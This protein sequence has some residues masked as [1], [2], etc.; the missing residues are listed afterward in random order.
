MNFSIFAETPNPTGAKQFAEDFFKTNAPR[1]AP[2][3]VYQKPVL[4]QCY[5]S[6]SYK[7]TPVFVFQNVE[8]GF[9]VV[10]QN[11]NRF[12]VA[13]Y[14]PEGQ[15]QAD[16]VPPQLSSL[17]QFYEDSLQIKP[18]AIQKTSAG[19][20]VMTPLLDEAGISLNQFS[21]PEVGGCPTGCV[22]TAFVQI[23]AYYKYP[24]KGVGSHCYTHPTYG[25]LCADFGNTTYNWDNPT[26]EDYKKLS[27][28]V[29]IAMD[30]NYCESS[31]GS[32]PSR[33][34]YPQAMSDYFR[35]YLNNGFTDSYFIINEINNRRPAYA[36]LPGDPGHA[37]VLDGYDTDG[38][39]HINFGWGG[40]YN[41]YYVLNNNSTFTVGYKFG[42]NVSFTCFMTPY[43][44]KTDIQDS[45]AL[46]AV[47][48]SLNGSTGWDLKQPV[49]TWKGVLM[50]NGRVISLKLNNG[51]Y[52]T[53][54]G[55][56]PSEIGNL[57]AL[58]MLDLLGQFDGELPA[59]IANLTMLKT[60]SIYAGAGKLKAQLP[61][62]V[63]NLV[64]LEI[65]EIPMHAEG[66]IPSSIGSLTKLQR[67]V[68]NSGN[69]TGN[70]PNEIG[71]LKNLTYLNLK[72]NKLTGSIPTG[73][74]N[75][76]QL[77]EIHLDENQLSGSL[78][79][80]IGNLTE[81]VALTLNDNQLSGNL[82]ESM[83]N[84][85]KLTTLHLYNNQFTGE[86][87][88]SLGNLSLIKNLN[89]S[90]N[91]FISLP[92]EIDNW[93]NIV[94]LN[95]NNNQLSSLPRSINNLTNLKTLYANHNQLAELPENFGAFPSL[96]NIDLSY[97]Q[98][99]VF[100][101]E[102][103]LLTKLEHIS[104][105]KNKIKEFPAGITMLPTTLNYL[106]LDSNE[107][108]DRIPKAL[109]ENENLSS[110]LLSY[111]RFTFE[112]LPVSD[113]LRNG[114]GN[115]KPV[116]L[117]KKIFKTAIGDTLRI[118]IREI[119]PFTLTTNQYN[120]ISAEN[121]KAISDSPNPILTI[122]IND[123]NIKNKYYCKVTNPSSPTYTYV[124][125][126]TPFRLP[127]LNFVTTDTISFQLATE[128]ELIAEKYKNSYVVSS[129]NVP[130]K[131]VEDKIVT[132][133][134]PLKVRGAIKWQ[135]S[136]DGTTWFDLSENMSQNDLKANF[137]SVNQQELV[138]SPKT[139]AYYRCSVQDINCEPL[140]SDTI[141]VNPFGKVLY[142]ENV[143]VETQS[144][145]V[146]IDS[147]EVTIPEKIYDKDFRLTIVKLDN[148][149]SPPDSVVNIGSAYDVT[150][151][152]AETFET[153]LL[154][155]LKNIDKK[156]INDESIEQIKAMY[157]DNKTRKWVYYANSY[158]SLKDSSL[159][160]ETNHL[161]IVI[162]TLIK[163]TQQKEW[164]KYQRGNIIVYYRLEDIKTMNEK[165][166]QTPQPW[167][168]GNAPLYLQDIG[169]FLDQVRKS[170]KESPNNLPVP[171]YF[172]VYVKKMEDNDG[173]VGL[174]GMI[175]GYLTINCDIKS[176]TKL[177]S[178]LAHEYM[179]YTQDYY[180]SANPSNIFWM[181]ATAH[182]SDRMVW[183]ANTIPISESEQ[184]LLDGRT[185]SN[186][187]YDFLA[188][189][190]DYWDYSILTQNLWGNIYYC[191]LA[192]TFLHYMRSYREGEK[193]NPAA[194][195]KGTTWLGNWRNYLDSYIKKNLKSNIGDEYENFVKYLLQGSNNNFTILDIPDGP[196]PYSYIIAQSK[197]K[198]FSDKIVYRFDKNN[199][200]PQKD[201]MTFDIPYLATKIL[202]L[203]NNTPD[204]AVVV[205]YKRSHKPDENYKVYYGRYDDTQQQTVYVDIS[206]S[207]NYNI[208]I[209][210]HSEKATKEK[211]NLCFLLFINKTNPSTFS[212]NTDFE[213]SFEL[214][215]TPVFD[216]Q[217]LIGGW[218]AGND[219][220]NLFVHTFSQNAKYGFV[221]SG[222]HKA[223]IRSTIVSHTVNYYSSHRSEIND[224][225][226]V[227][228]VHFSDETRDEYPPDPLGTCLPTI[229]IS[230]KTQ[231]IVYNF[232]RGSIKIHSNEKYIN[233]FEEKDEN[234]KPVIYKGSEFYIDATLWVKNL[235]SMTILTGGDNVVFKTR[236]SAETQS[237]IEKMSYTFR[238][239]DFDLKGDPK[240]DKTYEY[241]STDYSSGDIILQLIFETK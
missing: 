4:R 149:P 72:G 101:E 29:G 171:E 184:Y 221:I 79:D 116:N 152:F 75:L 44:L 175:K 126:G 22:A 124:S 135:A 236:N 121:N 119:A 65:L 194:L 158:I 220:D 103:C 48:N 32:T 93:N 35:Y 61:E 54:K 67:L 16:S 36:E 37:V 27:F 8:K 128:E 55:S 58:Q 31:Y 241:Q 21:H 45:L 3:K 166:E 49:S 129:N 114:I 110:L 140:L 73:I 109:L 28:H 235:Y 104:F 229:Q 53:Y 11:N 203:Y 150:V 123:K 50:M 85:S 89:F 156:M 97:N 147:I 81:L 165:Y 82:P 71:N 91:K 224:S 239:V 225:S 182:L 230:E 210:A 60:L 66:T 231:R 237:A 7:A 52:F 190:W 106:A 238:D 146:K 205:N 170:F 204:R 113:Q 208:F 206:D 2:G 157:F 148:P 99:K 154:I 92:D 145:T 177:R 40:R 94:E 105:R 118:D 5:Q 130:S 95:L 202:M 13:G 120:W 214:T 23:M 14:A 98:L 69:L 198:K 62:N 76:T 87:P 132:L 187:I 133:V 47:H 227:V 173:V 108:K 59:S 193:L 26:N 19:E 178:V 56:I 84:C 162:P 143:N 107:I 139:P 218:V 33:S 216:I 192:G 46:V 127:C 168:S 64:N 240:A 25:E 217:N 112:D 136:S 10:A 90:N 195:L 207:T 144:Q 163:E 189:S 197:Y 167:H 153:P 111:N 186:S 183:G 211:K 57:T 122:I 185:S 70:I 181:E 41:G 80:N 30:M 6:A 77:T 179:H 233:Q 209:E 213:A 17:L 155:K 9:V 117:S 24:D 137:V 176:P 39:F 74:T 83:G 115:Q 100:P 172:T 131:I 142:D 212:W 201:E 222:V 191:Y 86:I 199:Q 141:K 161:T 38:L 78:P 160:F 43:P 151:S 68:L 169:E 18:A 15:F 134:P 96:N 1:F 138:L 215:A 200:T 159:L 63:G 180:I 88:A 234:D 102:L 34:D 196:N 20:P 51:S 226:Y 42:T 232:V 228:N 125:S 188:N 174:L 164:E 219:G 223:P 12:A